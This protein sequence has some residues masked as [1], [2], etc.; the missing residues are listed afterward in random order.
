[1]TNSITI[2][3]MFSGVGGLDLAVESVTGATPAWF[4]EWDD[5]PARVLD[6]HWPGMTNH[7]DVTTIDWLEVEAVDIITGGYPCQPFSRAGRRKGPHDERHLWPHIL[8]AIS[9]LHPRFAVL[10]NVTGHLTLGFDQVLTDLAEIGWDAEWT[11]LRASDIGAPHHRERLFILAYPRGQR[12]QAEQFTGRPAA[13]K[14]RYHD[15]LDSLAWS[16]GAADF[17][18]EMKLRFGESWQVIVTWALIRGVPPPPMVVDHPV[19]PLHPRFPETKAATNTA[20]VEWM[21]GLPSGW[22]T[23]PAIG[24][25][26]A[27]QLK[28][29]GNAV[30]PQQAAAALNTLIGYTNTQLTAPIVAR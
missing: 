3:S 14:P 25:T 12:P 1:M 16:V 11:T 5:A 30:V 2:G 13:E 23:D 20:L 4:C 6:H 8:R 28:A 9:T 26:R 19:R 22:V 17:G 18:H 29:L 21:M 7:R 15:V 27:Q 10:E 24:L